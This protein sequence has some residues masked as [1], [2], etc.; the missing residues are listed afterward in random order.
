MWYFHAD[1]TSQ[2]MQP[3][4]ED[5]VF[6]EDESTGEMTA[7]VTF[8]FCSKLLVLAAKVTKE[9]LTVQCV[10]KHSF[11]TRRYLVRFI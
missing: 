2:S 7:I 1:E 5:E 11:L 9:I 6:V 3:L 10:V 4:P 8:E